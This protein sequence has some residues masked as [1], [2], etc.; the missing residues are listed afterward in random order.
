MSAKSSYTGV[1]FGC[2]LRGNRYG[3][4][5]GAL[6]LFV[7]SEE[8]LASAY[9]H[10]NGLVWWPVVSDP[11]VRGCT[12]YLHA[13]LTRRIAANIAKLPE[14]LSLRSSRARCQAQLNQRP[15]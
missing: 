10:H 13:I 1:G 12:I 9:P 3:L 2:A 7:G 5:R 4:S 6:V 15:V 8:I 14:L 11:R